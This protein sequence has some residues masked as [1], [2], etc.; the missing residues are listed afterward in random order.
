MRILVTGSVGHLGE[1]LAWRAVSFPDRVRGFAR[2]R[3]AREPG[4]RVHD[5]QAIARYG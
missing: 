3:P 5:A 1:A 4:A 2:A